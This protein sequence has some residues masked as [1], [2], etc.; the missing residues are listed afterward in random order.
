[1][2]VA[3]V[4]AVFSSGGYYFYRLFIALILSTTGRRF[5][6]IYPD[7]GLFRFL[8]LSYLGPA[9]LLQVSIR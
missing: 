4:V 9:L 5:I 3:A 8:Q 7:L 6:L 2:S 1:M